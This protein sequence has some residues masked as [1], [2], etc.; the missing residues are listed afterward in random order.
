MFKTLWFQTHWLFGVTA[1]LVLAVMGVSGALLSFE[2]E[3]LRALNPL[4]MTVPARSAPLLT[5]PELVELVQ[6][7]HPGRAIGTVSVSTHPEHAARVGFVAARNKGDR[8]APNTRPRMDV[9]F[10]DPYSGRLLGAEDALRG[11]DTLHVFEDLHRRL[12]AG[13]TG[14]ALTG[15]ST[16]ILLVLAGSG[17][18][19]RVSRRQL[20][21]PRRWR[22]L[23]AWFAVRWRQ[24]KA[25]FL[26]SLHEVFG[27]WLLIPYLLVAL[28]GLWW[29]YDWYREG[30]LRLT[31]A[32]TPPR[33]ATRASDAAPTSTETLRD[34]WSAFLRATGT[35][36]YSTAS[37]NLPGAD[38]PLVI[39]YLDADPSH[40]RAS[41]RIA[42]D[43][44]S[45]VVRS[46]ER[47]A[48]RN[49]GGKL[50]ASMFALHKGSFFGIGGTVLMMIAS[51]AMPLFA[52]TGWLLYLQRRRVAKLKRAAEARIEA[53]EAAQ[54]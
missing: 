16:L 37:F 40:E 6:A 41:N 7:E 23:S 39:T 29:S 17:L 18:W 25:P 3:I 10:A 50:A 31:G 34:G 4:Q 43:P 14:K 32:S 5:P 53:S 9:Y 33:A 27:T 42:L 35:S 28:T 15:A 21:W 13:D 54:A 24:R 51:L 22:D 2:T 26:R 48:D 12:A 44:A 45:S 38:Q 52:I 11:H 47:Y 20:R 46:H 36:G 19:L 30:V 8:P 1:G 49:A